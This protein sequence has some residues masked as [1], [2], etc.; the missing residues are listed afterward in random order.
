MD[1]DVVD[2]RR[3]HA[4]P[5]AA[6]AAGDVVVGVPVRT[7]LVL[8]QLVIGVVDDIGEVAREHRRGRTVTVALASVGVD[9]AAVV[10][11]AAGDRGVLGAVGEVDAGCDETATLMLLGE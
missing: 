11:E 6:A 3:P 1:V 8:V 2:G 5:G 7:A 4:D 9:G 10:D